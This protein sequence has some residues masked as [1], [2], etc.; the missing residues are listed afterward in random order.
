MHSKITA[1]NTR[2]KFVRLL[3]FDKVTNEMAAVTLVKGSR[4]NFFYGTN[5]VVRIIICHIEKDAVVKNHYIRSI[6]CCH[7][8]ALEM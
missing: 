1:S 4:S 6:S 3:N 8:F 2:I 5:D 7:W